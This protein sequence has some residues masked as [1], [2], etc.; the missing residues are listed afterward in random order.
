MGLKKKGKVFAVIC[1][2][3]IGVTA[4]SVPA[5]ENNNVSF[6][7]QIGKYHKN[8]RTAKGRYRS[9]TNTNDAWKVQLIT[10]GEGNGTYTRF[11]LENYDEDNVSGMIKAQ[12]GEAA[13][14]EKASG[15]ASKAT[16]YLTGEN[17]NFNGDKYNVTG[18]WDEETGII[19]N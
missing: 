17:N 4:L 2:A 1:C 7:F 9:T 19:I 14:Y 3:I 16:V 13:T 6:S 18:I 15:K 8:G 10:S 11:W 12:Q 5:S